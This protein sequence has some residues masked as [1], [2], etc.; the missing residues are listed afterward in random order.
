MTIIRLYAHCI[1]DASLTLLL[2][3]FRRPLWGTCAISIIV[4]LITN[5][6]SAV[7]VVQNH[8]NDDSP[9]IPINMSIMR[10]VIND[11]LFVL[12]SVAFAVCL[13]KMTK[14]SSTSVIL[15]AKVW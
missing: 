3:T 2:L 11:S 9:S 14:V 15:E 8:Q 12:A 1:N 7:V 10:V 13:V 6:W 5:I 4:F